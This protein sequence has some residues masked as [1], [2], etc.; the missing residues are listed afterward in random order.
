M[1][2]ASRLR[3]WWKAVLH[4]SSFEHEMET[5]LHSHLENYADDLVR[6]GMDRENAMRRARLELG[7][8][9]VQKESCRRSIGLRPLDDLIGDLRY[10]SRQLRRAP[11]FTVTVLVV[12]ALGIGANAAMFSIV[13]ATLLR[14]LPYH[15]P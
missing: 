15:K 10:V 9:A 4:R 2:A 1:S 5:E 13:D 12:L 8:V 11:A 3:S 7:T 14:W 6:R